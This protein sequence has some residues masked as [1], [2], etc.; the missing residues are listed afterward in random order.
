M[1]IRANITGMTEDQY[2][3]ITYNLTMN[4]ARTVLEKNSDMV[5]ICVSGTGT[6]SREKSRMMWARVKGKTENDLLA[7][8]FRDAYMFRLRPG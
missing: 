5:F 2:R 4:L 3:H 7:M 8:P 6:D 1:K